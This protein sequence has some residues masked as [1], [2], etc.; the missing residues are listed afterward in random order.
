MLLKE[1]TADFSCDFAAKPI[2]S[3]RDCIVW[4]NQA[5]ENQRFSGVQKAELFAQDKTLDRNAYK[6]LPN[7]SR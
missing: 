6:P 2:Q 4:R 3:R 1:H 5:H 7:S